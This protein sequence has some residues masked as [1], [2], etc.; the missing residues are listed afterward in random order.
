M[1]GVNHAD[2][3]G[4][5]KLDKTLKRVR[6]DLI[7]IEGSQATEET[8]K[9]FMTTLLQGLAAS[10]LSREMQQALLYGRGNGYEWKR[11]RT[12]AHQYHA[13]IDFLND[14]TEHARTFQ[15]VDPEEVRMKAMDE[16]AYLLS[17]E[18][19]SR[20]HPFNAA[21]ARGSGFTEHLHRVFVNT[22]R[23]HELANV[24]HM[25][26]PDARDVTMATTLREHISKN[27]R[28]RIATVTGY[29]HITSRPT[30]DSFYD[31]VV[32]LNPERIFQFIE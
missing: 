15:S 25:P 6:P 24:G 1:I 13:R 10:G 19:L 21:I 14:E 17:H 22:P 30:R 27:T 28:A 9:I 5:R 12:Y 4:D 26:K 32:D 16:L 11:S 8:D 7:L 2:P 29:F 18:H 23:E 31:R 20:I 3:N